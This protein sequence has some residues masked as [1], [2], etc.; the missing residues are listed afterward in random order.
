MS[1]TII[2]TE[3]NE[4]TPHRRGIP[5]PSPAAEA[6][7]AE[8]TPHR[9]GILPIVAVSVLLVLESTPHRR[10]I[11]TELLGRFHEIARINPA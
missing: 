7:T 9:R 4:S 5:I 2:T 10:G 8:S 6:I 3:R 1:S 11:P